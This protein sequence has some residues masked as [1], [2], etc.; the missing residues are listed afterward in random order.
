MQANGVATVSG[1]GI[2]EETPD[3]VMPH[4]P[5]Q[6]NPKYQGLSLS[7]DED[8]GLEAFKTIHMEHIHEVYLF[9]AVYWGWSVI[10]Q[11]FESSIKTL[12]RNVARRLEKGVYKLG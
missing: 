1:H 11:E 12:D 2:L 7:E 6:I 10:I 5:T 3:D 4:S 9:G 8:G